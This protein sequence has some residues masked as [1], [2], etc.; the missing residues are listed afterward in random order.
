MIGTE[1]PGGFL[2]EADSVIQPFQLPKPQHFVYQPLEN[3]ETEGLVPDIGEE[4]DQTENPLH[5]DELFKSESHRSVDTLQIDEDSDADGGMATNDLTPSTIDPQ[6]PLTS[7]QF[8]PKTMQEYAEQ[9]KLDSP[10]KVLDSEMD[11]NQGRD[12]QKDD[13][14]LSEQHAR[15]VTQSGSARKTGIRGSGTIRDKAK[16]NNANS[17]VASGRNK[18]NKPRGRRRESDESGVSEAPDEVSVKRTRN[19]GSRKRKRGEVTDTTPVSTRVLRSRV[20]KSAEKL[21]LEREAEDAF[22]RAVEE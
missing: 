13:S 6:M 22:R 7:G 21:R 11:T 5:T 2:T 15:S 20:P 4:K 9:M 8:A 16:G 1:H 3:N 10:D 14:S 19:T 17:S 12:L 18:V